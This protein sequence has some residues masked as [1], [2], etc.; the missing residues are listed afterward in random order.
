[1]SPTGPHGGALRSARRQPG[2]ARRRGQ[3]TAS[4]ARWTGDAGGSGRADSAR[5]MLACRQDDEAVIRALCRVGCECAI[6][7][8]D[9]QMCMSGEMGIVRE[10]IV[11]S[12]GQLVVDGH[13]WPGARLGKTGKWRPCSALTGGSLQ[14]AYLCSAA[15]GAELK[16]SPV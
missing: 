8:L 5:V 4:S 10:A 15:A 11:A 2:E 3:P 7:G 6:A 9:V 13:G 14:P 1:M 16:S 12:V